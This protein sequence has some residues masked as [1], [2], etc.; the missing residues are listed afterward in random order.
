MPIKIA[1]IFNRK[2]HSYTVFESPFLSRWLKRKPVHMILLNFVLIQ[3]KAWLGASYLDMGNIKVTVTLNFLGGN[4]NH[5]EPKLPLR[6]LHTGNHEFY[7]ASL[8]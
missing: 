7:P 3:N 8:G 5:F 1:A 2:M 6:K 4:T